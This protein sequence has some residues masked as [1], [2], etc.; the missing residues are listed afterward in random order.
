[1]MEKT[2]FQI[3][4][5]TLLPDLE[6]RFYE[7][8]AKHTSFK[9]GGEADIFIRPQTADELALVIADARQENVPF[10]IL[11]SGS[12]LIVSDGGIEGAVISTADINKIT[13]L[14][15]T[16]VYA[17]AGASLAALCCFA[18]DNGLTGLEFAYGIPGSV[19]GAVYMNAGAYGGEMKDVLFSC[20]HI[21]SKGDIDELSRDELNLRYRGSAYTAM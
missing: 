15:E 12:N 18:R 10:F 14:D 16:T 2:P 3:K 13:L 4:L 20:K 7:P 6:L 9:I 19:G 5:M 17:E 21:D 8:M 1:M 11:G